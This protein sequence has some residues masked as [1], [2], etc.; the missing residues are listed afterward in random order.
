MT[1]KEAKYWKWLYERTSSIEHCILELWAE[2]ETMEPEEKDSFI[3]F[4]HWVDDKM[5]EA[6]GK[7]FTIH[8][9]HEQLKEKLVNKGF[10]KEKK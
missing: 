6:Q 10:L 4:Y 1:L 7:L 9:E 5:N 3:K 8:S 2:I